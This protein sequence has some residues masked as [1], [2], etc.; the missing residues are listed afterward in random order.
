MSL[1]GPKMPPISSSLKPQ[2]YSTRGLML[3]SSILD[4]DGSPTAYVFLLASPSYRNFISVVDL[5]IESDG[6]FVPDLIPA[7][8]DLACGQEFQGCVTLLLGEG[9][10]ENERCSLIFRS[11][12][13]S[14][15]LYAPM[16][17]SPFACGR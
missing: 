14:S 11:A 6:R 7:C 8:V 12:V 9:A 13:S 2:T 10:S 15:P 5:N 17:P 4:P 16:E 1:G 3:H